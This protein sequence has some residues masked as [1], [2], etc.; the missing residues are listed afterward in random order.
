MTVMFCNQ[1][2][3]SMCLVEFCNSSRSLSG[4]MKWLH[5][6]GIVESL[7]PAKQKAQALL[8]DYSLC[9]RPQYYYKMPNKEHF[10]LFGFCFLVQRFCNPQYVKIIIM[11]QSVPLLP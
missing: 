4:N 8:T 1:D 9:L 5:I 10:T 6:L 3:F 7:H 11:V 2:S